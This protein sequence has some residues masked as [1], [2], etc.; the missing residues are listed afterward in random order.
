[1]C[2]GGG[3]GAGGRNFNA[4]LTPCGSQRR[5][6]R[7][8]PR[9]PRSPQ[10]RTSAPRPVLPTRPSDSSR[11]LSGRAVQQ[12]PPLKQRPRGKSDRIPGNPAKVG[13]RAKGGGVQAAPASVS[14]LGCGSRLLSR[15][16]APERSLFPAPNSSPG[17]C[18]TPGCSSVLSLACKAP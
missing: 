6:P 3:G 5:R 1:M 4:T 2:A 7:L 11:T 8:P 10:T 12:R 13:Q 18:S 16:P 17:P 15:L 14:E 9:A